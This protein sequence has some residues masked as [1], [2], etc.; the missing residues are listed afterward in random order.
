VPHSTHAVDRTRR[1]FAAALGY[2]VSAEE[3]A[4]GVRPPPAPKILRGRPNV[5][6]L[7]HGTTWSSKRW[8]ARYWIELARH[9]V[10]AGYLP[11]LPWSDAG[12]R[13]TA[14][15]VAAAAPPALVFP[16]CGL[17]QIS[18]LIAASRLVVGGD[19]GLLHLAAA[20][21][22]PTV[23]LFASTSPD[24]VGPLGPAD[25]VLRA[26]LE[27]APCGKRDCPLVPLGSEPPCH[28]TIGPDRVLAAIGPLR[29]QQLGLHAAR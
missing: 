26:T 15:A 11:V 19:T 22:V 5:A 18:G 4:S 24:L 25:R 29:T 27:C 21:G 10:A 12:E 1:L 6:V 9:L 3:P 28:A 13:A 14:E 2:P 8:P 23:S 20:F 7:L 16:R 17:E